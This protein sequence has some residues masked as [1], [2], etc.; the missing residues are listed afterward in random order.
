MERALGD[1]NFTIH[2]NH[3]KREM[4][5]TNRFR[6]FVYG[7]LVKAIAYMKLEAERER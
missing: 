7:T 2:V 4:V 5:V 6:K 1:G 3:K